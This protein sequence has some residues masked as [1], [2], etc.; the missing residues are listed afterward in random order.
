MLAGDDE[1]DIKASEALKDVLLHHT[2][3]LDVYSLIS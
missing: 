1:S 3:T 2:H